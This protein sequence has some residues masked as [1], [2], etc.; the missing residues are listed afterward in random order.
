LNRIWILKKHKEPGFFHTNK[1][2]KPSDPNSHHTGSYSK[3]YEHVKPRV[4]SL[5]NINHTP[6]GGNV[7]IVDEKLD[8]SN[9]TP[10]V[11]LLRL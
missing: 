8:F 2:Q 5:A 10:K 7:K 11:G 1:Y 4:G 3:K 6:K 9:V